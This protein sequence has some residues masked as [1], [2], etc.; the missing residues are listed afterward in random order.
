MK[1]TRVIFL[2]LI[3]ACAN[4]PETNPTTD[5]NELRNRQL[6]QCYYESDLYL[7]RQSGKA[8]IFYQ[9]GTEGKV[10]NAR[11]EKSNFKDPNLSTCILGIIKGIKYMAPQD[12]VEL[13]VYYP[14]N[15]YPGVQ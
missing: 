12:G 9:I 5:L 8:E 1:V 11:I 3:S 4:G 14:L 2:F 7:A 15:F 13:D 6:K 10:T